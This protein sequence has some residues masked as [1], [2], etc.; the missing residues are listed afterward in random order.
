MDFGRIYRMA[1]EC[2]QTTEFFNSDIYWFGTS[3]YNFRYSSPIL[4]FLP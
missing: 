1:M 2:N 4:G 3:L